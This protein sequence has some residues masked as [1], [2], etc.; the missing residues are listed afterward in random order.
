MLLLFYS[1]LFLFC[2]PN[3]AFFVC[4]KL[5]VYRNK[6]MSDF[7]YKTRQQWVCWRITCVGGFYVSISKPV[8]PWEFLMLTYCLKKKANGNFCH[9]SNSKHTV[10][11]A[12]NKRLEVKL[13][14]SALDSR[15]WPVMLKSI[16]TSPKLGSNVKLYDTP[17]LP[18][19]KLSHA[20]LRK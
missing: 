14:Q 16:L 4:A 15:Q 5:G 2:A 6:S 11:Y 7:H 3:F 10:K 19:P 17:V 18:S 1:T 20:D 9:Y 8:R 13:F 12:L